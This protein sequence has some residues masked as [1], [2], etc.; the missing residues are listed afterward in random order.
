MKRTKEEI[1]DFIKG[2][3]IV[4]CQMEPHAPGYREDSV[5]SLAEAAIWAG[6]KGLRI[7]GLNNIM[8]IRAIT[9]LPI[10]GLI[11]VFRN[12]TE[13]FM[14]P[15]IKEVRDVV[16]AGADIIAIDG[17]DRLIDGKK[18]F[19]IINEIKGKYP[20][21][22]I[23]ADVRDEIDA[24]ESFK[25]G[26]DMVAPTF[27]RFKK[28]AKSVDEPDWEMFA[29][30]CRASKDYGPV[31]M[32]GKVWTVDDAIKAM[33]YGAHAVVVG[34]AITRPHIIAQRF[35]DH[36]EGFQEKRGLLY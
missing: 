17:T 13:V 28:D 14:T 6:A 15:T 31:L 5:K 32:E 10:I 33:Y 27:Y 9:D 21:I 26:A 29:K 36:L 7:N 34:S 20:D 12:D 8:Q 1:I 3:L 4:S 19:S 18:G 30:L 25:L 24:V 22:I 16:E 11:K 2:G 23:L 35:I